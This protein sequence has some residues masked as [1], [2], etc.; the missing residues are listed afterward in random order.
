VEFQARRAVRIAAAFKAGK[1]VTEP[2][3]D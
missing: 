2:A 3:G 1:A